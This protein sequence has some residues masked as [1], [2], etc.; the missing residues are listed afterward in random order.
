[1]SRKYNRYMWWSPLAS[2][3]TKTC[4]LKANSV[5][6]SCWTML[7]SKV[8]MR[9]AFVENSMSD[10]MML[11]CLKTPNKCET[12]LS[13]QDDLKKINAVCKCIAKK[14]NHSSWIFLP[15]LWLRGMRSR[16]SC[17][18]FCRT[19]LVCKSVLIC[20]KRRE[21]MGIGANW[22]GC[23]TSRFNVRDGLLSNKLLH[24]CWWQHEQQLD[25]VF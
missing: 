1:M 21:L 13:E 11:N 23:G 15:K 10:W 24:H 25:N 5:Q 7:A 2:Q 12:C 16:S 17:Q 18:G 3:S 19:L 14:W 20:T 4:S 6:Y 8:C 22:V 9:C